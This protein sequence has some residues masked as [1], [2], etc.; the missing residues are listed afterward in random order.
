[1]FLAASSPYARRGI[2]WRTYQR[3]WAKD[4]ATLV[5]QADTRTM[6]PTV[7]QSIID[8]AHAEDPAVAAAEYLAQWRIDIETFIAREVIEAAVEPRVFEIPRAEGLVYHAFADPSGGAAD[9]MCLA[10]AHRDKDKVVVLDCLKEVRAPFD[11]DEVCKDFAETL[12]SYGLMEVEGDKYGGIWPT[13]R[14]EAHGIRYIASERTKSQIYLEALPLFMARRVQLLDH[15]PMIAQLCS[16]ERH[17]GRIGK[18]VVDHPPGSM[19]DCANA[20]TGAIVAAASRLTGADQWLAIGRN[21]FGL[22]DP[23]PP[24]APVVEAVS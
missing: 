3:N 17:A 2:A 9:S 7:P 18:D 23:P 10:V 20:A 13:E 24:P 11:P 21:F 12:H 15:R 5:W 19:D 22:A 16:L 14:F 6:N 4:T 1:M 8:D